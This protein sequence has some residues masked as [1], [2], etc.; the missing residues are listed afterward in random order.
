[1]KKEF[2]SGMVLLVVVTLFIVFVLAVL[3]SCK[4]ITPVIIYDVPKA[5]LS[6][7]MS[8]DQYLRNTADW[9]VKARGYIEELLNQI[10]HKVPFIDAR[11]P[12]K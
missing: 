3:P 11:T 10:T 7:D 5:D 6:D 12:E 1:M 2:I 9:A 8:L 4:T